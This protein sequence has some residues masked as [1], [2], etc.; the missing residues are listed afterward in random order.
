MTPTQFI[1]LHTISTNLGIHLFPVK[2]RVFFHV[3]RNSAKLIKSSELF[4]LNILNLH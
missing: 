1:Q 4:S 3:E 2:L